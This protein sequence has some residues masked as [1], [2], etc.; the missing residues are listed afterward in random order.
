MNTKNLSRSQK[1]ILALFILVVLLLG[2]LY[3]RRS[4]ETRVAV[5]PA[6]PSKAV[7]PTPYPLSGSYQ[8]TLSKNK[9][10]VGEIVT[11]AIGFTAPN[12]RIFGTDIVLHFDPK[13]LEAAAKLSVNDYFQNY[14]RQ[15][16]D[17]G[18]GLIKVTAFGP[19][20]DVVSTDVNV[21]VATFTAKKAGTTSL[22]F[23]FEKR[24]T[25]L[26]TLVEEGTS[27]NI[28][29]EANPVPVVVEP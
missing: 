14:P 1:I 13:T 9:Y 7:Q 4:K 22:S 21:F 27:R 23:D 20:G 18:K 24:K 3:L 11:A 6:E 25:N 29:S 5:K 12:K 17:K 26:T 8:I 10:K 2:F 28:L 16:V 19:K 15:E